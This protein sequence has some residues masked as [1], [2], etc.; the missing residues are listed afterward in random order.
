[1]QFT[2]EQEKELGTYLDDFR[3]TSLVEDSNVKMPY[4]ALMIK[5]QLQSLG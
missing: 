5:E 1:M 3:K 4:D 2:Q